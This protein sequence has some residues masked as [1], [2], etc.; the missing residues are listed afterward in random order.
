MVCLSPTLRLKTI[1]SA[2][3]WGSVMKLFHIVLFVWDYY[4]DIGFSTMLSI[5]VLVAQVEAFS[6]LLAGTAASKRPYWHAGAAVAFASLVTIAVD[7]ALSP[8]IGASSHFR[9]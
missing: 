7:H 6:V 8:L 2:W 5:A 4:R 3:L 1:I 9:L